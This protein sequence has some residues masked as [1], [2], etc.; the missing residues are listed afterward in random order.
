MTPFAE[1]AWQWPMSKDVRLEFGDALVGAQFF[2]CSALMPIINV[3]EKSEGVEFVVEELLA[4]ELPADSTWI[5]LPSNQAVLIKD[6][7][8]RNS[9]RYSFFI[10]AEFKT[11][12]M[13]SRFD[14]MTNGRTLI[15]DDGRNYSPKYERIT[16]AFIKSAW[17]CIEAMQT[18]GGLCHEVTREPSR[19]QLRSANGKKPVHRWIEIRLGR[20]RHHSA[21]CGAI[22]NGRTVAWH[23]RRG[24]R[25]NHPNPN[26]PKW[27]KGCWAGSPE[28]GIRTHSYT[29]EVPG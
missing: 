18:P 14:L 26:Y 5:E 23:Y 10:L 25:V 13:F 22:D 9:I 20:A 8:S 24:H 1:R 7:K 3:R 4:G 27:R 11:K 15:R 12:N 2:D 17:F 28:A 6:H 29:V 19:Q 16:S 21:P